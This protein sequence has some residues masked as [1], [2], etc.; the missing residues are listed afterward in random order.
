MQRAP[1]LEDLGP[2]PDAKSRADVQLIADAMLTIPE[3]ARAA[4]AYDLVHEN[5]MQLSFEDPETLAAIE[6]ARE[7]GVLAM[8]LRAMF[9]CDP[10][11]ADALIKSAAGHCLN[12]A[13]E[14]SAESAGGW[15]QSE[16]ESVYA[17]LYVARDGLS[18][19]FG[20]NVQ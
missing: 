16:I 9:A 14:T 7:A 15:N 6:L 10:T 17:A 11:A 13:D 12:G 5:L 4:F 19:P 18:I 8:A 20:S 3:A 2:L 1:T